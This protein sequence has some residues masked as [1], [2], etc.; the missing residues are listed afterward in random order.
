MDVRILLDVEPNVQKERI[1][2]RSGEERL[3][4]FLEKWIPME[5]AYFEAYGIREAADVVLEYYRK[6]Q[7]E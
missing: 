6:K 2:R 5:E 4:A 1:L 3:Q 7:E